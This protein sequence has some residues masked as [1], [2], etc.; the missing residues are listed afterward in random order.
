M[1]ELQ[2]KRFSQLCCWELD[3][4]LLKVIICFSLLLSNL[5]LQI[6]LLYIHYVEENG[7][8]V[9]GKFFAPRQPQAQ[10]NQEQHLIFKDSPKNTLVKISNISNDHT[11]CQK[12]KLPS[13]LKVSCSRSSKKLS[14]WFS[15]R[16]LLPFVSAWFLK[17]SRIFQGSCEDDTQSDLT[18]RR[19]QNI[20]LSRSCPNYI[21]P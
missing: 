15:D 5:C 7:S 14:P 4:E 17:F 12:L 13:P 18:P 20:G 10:R 9:F 16:Q 6:K 11:K 21:L 3:P 19:K 1:C 2:K 8:M